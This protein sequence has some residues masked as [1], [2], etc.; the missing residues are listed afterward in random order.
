[1]DQCLAGAT[2]GGSGGSPW[3]DPAGKVSCS[4]GAARLWPGL[5]RGTNHPPP[6]RKRQGNPVLVFQ[7]VGTTFRGAC[8]LNPPIT[9][10]LS[11]CHEKKSPFLA[12]VQLCREGEQEHK[13]PI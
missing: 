4:L 9:T 2:T 3:L 13:E 8:T 6:S 11:C 7:R 10:P 5:R 1:M 12:P